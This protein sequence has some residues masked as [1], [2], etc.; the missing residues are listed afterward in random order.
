ML[1]TVG[2]TTQNSYLSCRRTK[3]FATQVTMQ[4][5]V[6]LPH[7]FLQCTTNSIAH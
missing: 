2:K 6:V 3:E 5:W 4:F 1:Y 7:S